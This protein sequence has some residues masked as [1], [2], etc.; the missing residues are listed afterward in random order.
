MREINKKKLLLENRK[1]F[2]KSVSDYL[3]EIW[4]SEWI[5]SSNKLCGSHLNYNET[6][7]ILKGNYLLDKTIE[8]HMDVKSHEDAVQLIEELVVNQSLLNSQKVCTIHSVLTSNNI[9]SF[10]LNNPVVQSIKYIPPHFKEVPKLMEE[11]FN[12]YY[13]QAQELNII[14]RAVLLHNKLIEIYPFETATEK[15]ARAILNYQLLKEGLPPIEFNI[16]QDIYCEMIAQYLNRQDFSNFYEMVMKKVNSRLDLFL[17][18][19]DESVSG[20]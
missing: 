12:W 3:R 6:L 7:T 9:N 5:Y 14:L 16:D 8:D 2:T 4:I 10:R 1:P 17:R 19:T 18:L 15:T 13:S 11:L 20:I